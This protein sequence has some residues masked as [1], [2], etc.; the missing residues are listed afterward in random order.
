MIVSMAHG[1]LIFLTLVIL[2][3]RE[4]CVGQLMKALSE[5]YR[6]VDSSAIGTDIESVAV[7]V[8]YSVFLSVKSVQVYKLTIH[9]K[10][11]ST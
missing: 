3:V 6:M 11:N 2:Q 7:D 4:H 8:E 10:V 1:K 9:K 5:N